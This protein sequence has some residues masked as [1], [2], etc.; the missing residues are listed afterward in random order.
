MSKTKR[1]NKTIFLAV[2]ILIAFLLL[3]NIFKTDFNLTKLT[4][5]STADVTGEA[6]VEGHTEGDNRCA[7]KTTNTR[8]K[9]QCCCNDDRRTIMK[10]GKSSICRSYYKDI[11]GWKYGLNGPKWC[12]K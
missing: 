2:V 3:F 5:G 11:C 6:H 12:G 8:K 10:E 1:Q 9:V 4:S 7:Y